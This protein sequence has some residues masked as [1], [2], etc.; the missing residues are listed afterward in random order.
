[1]VSIDDV[2]AVGREIF[3]HG[4]PDVNGSRSLWSSFRKGHQVFI[5]GNGDIDHGAV[6]VMKE[7][8]GGNGHHFGAAR[9][10]YYKMMVF[11]DLVH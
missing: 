3:W 7:V 5:F 11:G 6:E 1:M 4:E 10:I 2:E 9:E 8:I